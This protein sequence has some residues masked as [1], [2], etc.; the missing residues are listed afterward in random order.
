MPVIAAHAVT[1]RL[2]SAV[3]PHANISLYTYQFAVMLSLVVTTAQSNKSTAP[4]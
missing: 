3:T 4:C 2:H 1:D